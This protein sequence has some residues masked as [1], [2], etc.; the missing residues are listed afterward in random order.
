MTSLAN[1][2]KPV[3]VRLDD[4]LLDPNNPRFSDLGEDF[5][6]VQEGRYADNKVQ[7]HTLERMKNPVFDVVE[8]RDTI[9]ALGFLPMDKLVLRKWKGSS[10]PDGVIKYVVIE[11]NRRVTALKWLIQLHEVGKETFSEEQIKNFT[12]IEC[13]LIDDDLANESAYLILPG[14][15]HVSGIKEWGPYQ[16]AKAVFALRLS[17]MTAQQ[18]AQSLGLSTRAANSAYRCYLALEAMKS[19]EEFGDYAKPKLYSYFEEVFKKANLKAW[20]GWSDESETFTEQDKLAEFYSWIAPVDGED[21]EKITRAI[22]VRNLAAIIEDENALSILRS[23][24]GSLTRAMARYELD[25]PTDWLPKIV[26]AQTALSTLTPVLLRNMPQSSVT[27]LEEL[28]KLIG[29]TLHDREL[30]LKNPSA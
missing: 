28:Q 19:D 29:Q 23:A 5:S 2:L 3:N 14:L 20:L 11:G 17:G 22:D 9:K 16:K 1:I 25:N 26:A 24:D 18:A 30:L 27:V 21:S 8:L 4:I 15:R 13:L 6:P 7:S 10:G 12:E